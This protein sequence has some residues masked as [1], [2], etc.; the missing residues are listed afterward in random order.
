LLSHAGIGVANW[1][2]LRSG[3]PIPSFE[4]V[5][6]NL[7]KVVFVKPANMGSSV[8]VSRVTDSDQWE[9]SVKDAFTYDSKILVERSLYGREMECA[10]LGNEFPK[11]SG[12]GEVQSGDVYSYEEKYTSG[13]SAKTIIPAEITDSELKKLQKTAIETY[14]I[15]ECRGL[16]RVDMFL[17]DTGN[18]FV[19]EVNTMPG[20]TSISMYPKLW[21]HEGLDYNQLL[22]QLIELAL[23]GKK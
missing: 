13:S 2:T 21:N 9:T 10:V 8:G 11:A 22:D 1:I 3:S 18:V 5:T 23:S 6:R 7:G 4:K 14:R 17:D 12:V 16:S 20:F 19:N 15:L